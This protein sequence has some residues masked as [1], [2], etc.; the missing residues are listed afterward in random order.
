MTGAAVGRED[1]LRRLSRRIFDERVLAAIAAVPRELFV[2]PAMAAAAYVDAPLRIG[3]GQTISQPTVVARMCELLELTPADRVLDVG[4]GSG[5][6]A[7]VLAQL[8]DHVWGVELDPQLAA[9]AARAL[10]RA[11]IHNVTV[12][13]GDGAQGLPEYAPFD[14]IN[15][16]ATARDRVP[17]A[18]EEQLA[19]DGRL[20]APVARG[21]DEHLVR[22]RRDRA[23]GGVFRESLEAVRF[24]PL[25]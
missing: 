19:G 7:A 8:C 18:L 16:A 10:Q 23:T 11:G 15:V 12:S 3:G 9:R 21:R 17:A 5:Y 24:V 25:R 20:V 14:A 6:H 22:V 4:T 13:A 1:L 2:S